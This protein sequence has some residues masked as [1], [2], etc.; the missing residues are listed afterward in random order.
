MKHTTLPPVTDP[1]PPLDKNPEAKPFPKFKKKA[2]KIM[3]EDAAAA[4]AE[5]G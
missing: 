1:F 4:L 2:R 3:A 5:K